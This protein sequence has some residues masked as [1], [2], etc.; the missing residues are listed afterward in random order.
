MFTHIVPGYNYERAENRWNETGLAQTLCGHFVTHY[1]AYV[2]CFSQR[3]VH[4]VYVKQGQTC[5]H[6][7]AVHLKRPW[8]AGLG[9]LR[10]T[11]YRG[12]N[13]RA[14]RQKPIILSSSLQELLRDLI[15]YNKDPVADL[16][17]NAATEKYAYYRNPEP[18]GNYITYR[19]SAGLL[20]FMP[21]GRTQEYT[22]DGKWKRAGRQDMKPGRLVAKLLHPRLVAKIKPEILNEFVTRF[23]A[24]E[25]SHNMECFITD[26]VAEA[27]NSRNFAKGELADPPFDSCMW[28]DDVSPFYEAMGAKAIICKG[29]DG[30][31]KGRA[32]LWPVVHRLNSS[33]VVPDQFQ[34]MDRIYRESPEVEETMKR[35]ALANNIAHKKNQNYD[36]KCEIIYPVKDREGNVEG[37]YQGI[38]MKVVPEDR[39]TIQDSDTYY[40]YVDTFTYLNS[41]GSCYNSQGKCPDFRAEMSRTD[42]TIEDEHEG[43]VE[44]HDGEWIDEDDAV[45]INGNCYDRNSDDVVICRRNSEYI[46]REEAYEIQIERNRTIW[47]HEDHVSH[48]G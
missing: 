33:D 12:W 41:N 31:Y 32:I 24:G 15:K 38:N 46:L 9:W 29:G 14:P 28:D 36:D 26:N 18:F 39:S 34:L 30:R 22:D 42:G 25:Q 45:Y 23:K 43:Q 13:R 16:L 1:E 47:I 11:P 21:H 37:K 3:S 19:E 44:T 10:Y 48:G 6:C 40:P 4:D 8:N 27:Y 7:R 35:W 5:P 2:D 20:S 17:L